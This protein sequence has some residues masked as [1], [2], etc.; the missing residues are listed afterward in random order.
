MKHR[1]TP[2]F[3]KASQA[4]PAEVKVQ[5][6][7]AF[8]LFQEDVSHPSFSIE[9]IEGYP[10]VWLGRISRKFGGRFTLSKILRR[11][12]AFVCIA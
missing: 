7:K 5:A 11:A 3:V 9:R 10:G 2:R 12:S 1:G 6:R 4:L 8:L